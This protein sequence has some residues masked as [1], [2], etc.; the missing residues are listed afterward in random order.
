MP[1][2]LALIPSWVK[3]AAVIALG[4]VLLSTGAYLLGRHDEA[5]ATKAAQ[6][7]QTLN[8]LQERAT[9]D[10]KIKAMPAYDLCVHN[11]GLPDS[12]ASALRGVAQDR[13]KAVNSGLPCG[14]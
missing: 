8:A 14:Q 1:A 7:E 3:F 2:L 6:A 4:A 10:E 9:I 13:P 12:C 5:A 11:G